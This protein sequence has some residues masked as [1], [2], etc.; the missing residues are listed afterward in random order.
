MLWN[1]EVS[2]LVELV[3]GDTERLGIAE[4][5]TPTAVADDESQ[6]AGAE[7][8]HDAGLA[9]RFV[10]VVAHD[11]PAALP[12]P[13]ALLLRTVDRILHENKPQRSFKSQHQRFP[14]SMLPSHQEAVSHR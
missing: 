6:A 10:A 5:A 12:A 8:A 11:D 4:E 3:D 9:E 2:E 1:W 7:V 13:P 14:I